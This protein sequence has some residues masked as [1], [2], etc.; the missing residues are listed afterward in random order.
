MANWRD[1]DERGCLAF[2]GTMEL[3]G[4]RWNASILVSLARGATRFREVLGDVEGLSDRM[5]ALRLRELQLAGLVEREVV[6]SM[7]VQIRY[8]LSRAGLDL[9]HA[10]QP[11]QR[12]GSAYL[13]PHSSQSAG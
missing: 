9:M 12:W 13:T 4:L 6:P 5:L 8:T 1:I 2:R 11:L 3:I 10:L 7:P